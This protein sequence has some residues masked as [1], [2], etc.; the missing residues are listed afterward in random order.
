MILTKRRVVTLSTSQRK[1]KG[2]RVD[3]EYTSHSLYV[4][5]E[6]GGQYPTKQ[7]FT[8]AKN[9]KNELVFTPITPE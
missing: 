3:A 4:P 2:I 5:P 1:R 6:L 9:K 8:V 7:K